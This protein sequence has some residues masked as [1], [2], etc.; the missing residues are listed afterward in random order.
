MK[1]INQKTILE[2]A[3]E[4]HNLGFSIIPC[5]RFENSTDEAEKK[6]RK[7]PCISWTPYQKERASL[8]QI[9]EWFSNNDCNIGVVLGTISNNLIAIDFDEP[10]QFDRWAERFKHLLDK[11]P[12]VQ[13]G[14]PYGRHVYFRLRNGV[15]KRIANAYFEGQ[16][17][18]EIRAEKCYNLIAPSI[19]PNDTSYKIITPF[20][21]GIIEIE[22]VSE[23]G[24]YEEASGKKP[25][26]NKAEEFFISDAP[27]FYG[28]KTDKPTFIKKLIDDLESTPAGQRNSKLN[29]VAYQVG[30]F[31]SQN[32]IDSTSIIH[33]LENA[34]RS[35]GLEQHEVL[36]TIISGFGAGL[37]DGKT[38]VQHDPAY[39][40]DTANGHRFVNLTSNKIKFT[41]EIGWLYFNGKRYE[42]D[43]LGL[44]ALDATHLVIR[45][46]VDELE[47]LKPK[48]EDKNDDEKKEH[49]MITAMRKHIKATASYKGRKNITDIS[50]SMAEILTPEKKLDAN[51]DLFNCANGIVRLSDI[52]LLPHDAQYL[53]TK[54]SDVEYDAAATCPV[55]MNFLDEIFDHDQEL[56]NYIQ[57]LFGYSLTGKP[58]EHLL[59]FFYGDGNNGKST[60]IDIMF[61]IFGDY[62]DKISAST[63]TQKDRD[64]SISNDVAR[65]RG[66]RLVVSS[67]LEDKRYLNESLVKDLTGGDLIVARFLHKEY[68]SFKPTFSIIMYGNHYPQIKGCDNGIRRRIR[69]VP[70]KVNIPNPDK[71]FIKK[72]RAEASGILNWVLTGYKNYMDEGFDPI[73]ACVLMSTSEYFQEND[74]TQQFLDEFCNVNVGRSIPVDVLYKYYRFWCED[75]KTFTET[76]N[77][78]GRLLKLKGFEQRKIRQAR[79][80]VGLDV[81]EYAQIKFSNKRSSCLEPEDDDKVPAFDL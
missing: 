7:Q 41:P 57:K 56:I 48:L 67:E 22:D 32:E 66:S 12:I 34:G 79:Q 59:H 15:Q 77:G 13:T 76:K 24:I 55:F 35:I 38:Y 81:N 78:F 31:A 18:G 17:I 74:S 58:K 29:T 80:W 11:T 36:P 61:H 40:S 33:E 9:K 4:Y 52:S 37:K 16:R 3:I 10:G 19:H 62:A 54:I 42:Y 2:S 72:L 28:K 53:I 60:L 44:K 26:K 20:E 45:D 27:E 49:P 5:Y 65:L 63:L 47:Q 23:I 43:I 70:F 39:F 68:F 25:R 50:S 30:L 1:T 21:V 73:P 64:N 69:L 71:D 8:T 51:P 46:L 6:R 75:N 14:K